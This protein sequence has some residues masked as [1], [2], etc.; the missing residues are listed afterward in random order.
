MRSTADF[1]YYKR[2]NRAERRLKEGGKQ[3]CYKG[4]ARIYLAGYTLHNI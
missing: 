4:D 3:R 1:M 2:D